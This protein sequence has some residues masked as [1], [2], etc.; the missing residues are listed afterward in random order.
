MINQNRPSGREFHSS[1]PKSILQHRD[2]LM[3]KTLQCVQKVK[4]S[5]PAT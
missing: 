5:N 1:C 3:M 2:T 4:T